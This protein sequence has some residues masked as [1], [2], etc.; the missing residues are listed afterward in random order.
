MVSNV[1][2]NWTWF[3]IRINLYRASL[4]NFSII[5][6]LETLPEKVEKTP[7]IID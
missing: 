4:I 2:K 7:D 1:L 6:Q 3:Q 5:D